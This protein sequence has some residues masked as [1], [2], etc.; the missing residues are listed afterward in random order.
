MSSHH[1]V[2]E[3]QEPA[4]LILSDESI[5]NELLGQL[6]EWSPIVIVDEHALFVLNH[7]PIKIDV[8]IKSKQSEID[9]SA[10]VSSQ[11]HIII[12]E[13][14][15][16][17]DPLEIC[18]NYLIKE[19]HTAL[20]VIACTEDRFYTL[21]TKNVN[22]DFI[23][24]K[25]EKKLYLIKNTFKKWKSKGS[26]FI[27]KNTVSKTINLQNLDDRY[28]V[29]EDGLVVISTDEKIIIEEIDE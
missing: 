26:T 14:E 2:K 6:L 4:L 28:I 27:I 3:K 8:I 18:I 10:F 24:Y 19:N 16:H 23:L 5:E 7:H 9:L 22:L 21:L 15:E 17:Q 29:I 12:L 20:N 11:D 25:P 13:R 1:F